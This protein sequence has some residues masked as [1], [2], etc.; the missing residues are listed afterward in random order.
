V[1]LEFRGSSM[2]ER[3]PVKAHVPGSNPG[4]GAIFSNDRFDKAWYG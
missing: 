3:R 1:M 2:V 4:P